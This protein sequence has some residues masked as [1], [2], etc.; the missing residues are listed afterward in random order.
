MFASLY[1]YVY[2]HC[3]SREV[4]TF[5]YTVMLELHDT[6][7]FSRLKRNMY[8]YLSIDK[9]WNLKQVNGPKHFI[10]GEFLTIIL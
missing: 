6:T 10:F 7:H 5:A 4:I 3:Y 2:L 8:L 9:Q 1:I